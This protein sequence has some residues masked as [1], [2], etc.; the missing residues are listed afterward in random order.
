[1]SDS[2]T[3][4]L[5]TVVSYPGGEGE[6]VLGT[7]AGFSARAAVLSTE[8][9]LQL[10]IS[11]PHIYPD[12]DTPPNQYRWLRAAQVTAYVTGKHSRLVLR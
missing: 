6:G 11:V 9:P 3:L 1:M 8:P 4:E 7:E 12:H 2:L 10:Q 5:Q